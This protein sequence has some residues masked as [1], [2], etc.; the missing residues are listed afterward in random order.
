MFQLVGHNRFGKSVRPM[1]RSSRGHFFL[2]VNGNRWIQPVE[3]ERSN[4]TPQ[5]NDTILN[6]KKK[7]INQKG[8]HLAVPSSAFIS[9]AEKTINF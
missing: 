1:L 4:K 2:L 7:K 3:F 6:Y 9:K 8:R 5:P